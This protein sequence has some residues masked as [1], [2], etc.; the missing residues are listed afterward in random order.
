MTAILGFGILMVA[1]I[2]CPPIFFALLAL[3]GLALLVAAFN[4]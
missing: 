1:C 2:L 4:R 3:F